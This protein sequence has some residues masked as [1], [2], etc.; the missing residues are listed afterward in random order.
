MTLSLNTALA[1]LGLAMLSGATT[2]LGVAFALRLQRHPRWIA[3]GIG[4]S[5]GMMLFVSLFELI[6]EA[7]SL[8][9]LPVAA[10]SAGAGAAG[11]ALLH[12]LLPHTHLFEESGALNAGL[13]RGAYLVVL[14]LVLHDLPEGFA[15]ANSYLTAPSLGIFVAV[16]VA[17]HN[18]PEEFAMAVPAIALKQRRFLYQAAVVSALAEPAGAALGLAAAGVRP[19]LVPVFMSMA[20]GAMV[21]V[22]VHE[23]VPM[24]RRYGRM[25]LFAVGMTISGVVYAGLAWLILGSGA[26]G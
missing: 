14:G 1:V 20:A 12:W 15:M 25:S 8:A 11:F 24:A 21:F 10:V 18:I 6:P 26:A 16:A 23:L 4:F 19:M 13:L 9:G 17:L 5:A 22:A 3:A 2:L 7:R